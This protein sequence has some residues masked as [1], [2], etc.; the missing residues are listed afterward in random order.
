MNEYLNNLSTTNNF[1]FYYKYIFF[2]SFN[3]YSFN[4]NSKYVSN[5]K[6]IIFID[7]SFLTVAWWKLPS[8]IFHHFFIVFCWSSFYIFLRISPVVLGIIL[9]NSIEHLW[10]VSELW[11][12]FITVE[13]LLFNF[14]YKC[15]VFINTCSFINKFTDVVASHSVTPKSSST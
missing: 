14:I 7:F 12:E 1:L 9:V 3:Y 6:K 4:H 2:L 11:L 10:F 15:Q 5:E 8:V 13:T